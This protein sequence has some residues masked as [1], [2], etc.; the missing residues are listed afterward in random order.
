MQTEDPRANELFGGKYIVRSVIGKGGMGVVY[1]VDHAILRQP[2]AV[3][4]LRVDASLGDT[5]VE[6][7]KQE[8]RAA[9]SLT[10]SNLVHV[11]DYGVTKT[12][13]PYL[14]MDYFEGDSIARL[15]AKHGAFTTEQAL[16]VFI[17][18]CSGVAYMHAK[19]IVHRDIKPSNIVVTRDER[20][21]PVA[22]ILDFGLAKF[23]P[24]VNSTMKTLTKTGEIF[25][26]P[27]YMSPEQCRGELVDERSDI[28]SLACVMYE[29]VTGRPP[30]VGDTA[31]QT[32]YKHINDQPLPASQVNPLVPA[33][34][35][36]IIMRALSKDLQ[37]RYQS[38]DELKQ[39]LTRVAAG[40]EPEELPPTEQEAAQENK[41][42]ILTRIAWA[43][44][45]VLI[46]AA[47]GFIVMH[48]PTLPWQATL[49]Q[50]KEH[51]EKGDYAMA[52]MAYKQAA[53]LAKDAS[54]G[55]KA[56][57]NIA[58]GDTC[59]RA[60]ADRNKKSIEDALSHYSTA[61]PLIDASNQ[62]A[63][64][65][66][67]E[68]LG[69]CLH[70]LKQYDNAE[71]YFANAAEIR[72]EEQSKDP[73]A[74]AAVLM[75]QGRNFRDNA[76]YEKAEPVLREAVEVMQKL[77]F[78]KQA[79]M[80]QCLNA[81]SQIASHHKETHRAALLKEAAEVHKSISGPDDAQLPGLIEKRNKLIEQ[82]YTTGH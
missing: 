28:Y 2:L 5:A 31:V 25:G 47:S 29:M 61:L 63:I 38:T 24:T 82:A 9:S 60:G 78:I 64:A 18:I 43:A 50:A 59:K 15:I 72:R 13:A 35:S 34:I 14:V 68:G 55:E 4:V 16:P 33:A 46:V 11:Q 80:P 23:L 81:L 69:D 42:Q 8:A 39:D 48:K 20:G 56:D 3:K 19:G 40:G 75:K 71:I 51:A 17:Q 27:L 36:A 12:G 21:M 22:K 70:G 76:K 10:H 30:L 45:V 37:I 65:H 73:Y 6:R 41:K 52:E 74:L 53:T 7:F 26:S 54:P 58:W 57:I 67:N 1:K 32:I 49:D 44:L 62:A 77:G 66:T 79:Y